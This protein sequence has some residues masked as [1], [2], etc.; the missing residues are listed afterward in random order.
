MKKLFANEIVL[1]VV[2][3]LVVTAGV[4][5]SYSSKFSGPLSGVAADWGHF[6]SYL[7]GVL[8]PIL[9]FSTL[10]YLA[11][12]LQVQRDLHADQ[13]KEFETANEN[14]QRQIEELEKANQQQQIAALRTELIKF[15]N[16]E[17]AID[18]KYNSD[19]QERLEKIAGKGW[20]DDN[21]ANEVKGLPPKMQESFNRRLNLRNISSCLITENFSNVEEL[22]A[23]FNKRYGDMIKSFG[24]IY[25]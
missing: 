2:V 16:S 12:D 6:G 1:L 14:Q 9:L 3:M 15:I 11:R 13:K 23:Y 4:L 19:L 20:V 7:N 21:E 18:E 5:L 24:K 17:I 22:R 8:S 10:I 25:T